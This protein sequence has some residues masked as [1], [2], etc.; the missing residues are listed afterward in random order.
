M[1]LL[2]AQ[3]IDTLIRPLFNLEAVQECG[4]DTAP[5]LPLPPPQL[6][7][8]LPSPSTTNFLGDSTVGVSRKLMPSSSGVAS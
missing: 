6:L 2:Q 7:P 4:I 8:A 5:P 3:L 1:I